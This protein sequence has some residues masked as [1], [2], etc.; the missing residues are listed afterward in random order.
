M[1][2]WRRA[3]PQTCGLARSAGALSRFQGIGARLKYS[4]RPEASVTT[5]TALGSSISCTEAIGV[6]SVQ[7]DACGCACSTAATCLMIDGSNRDFLTGSYITLSLNSASQ[8]KP[9]SV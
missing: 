1:P 7:T 9:N 8:L 2:T 5:F 4:A 6:T 3:P